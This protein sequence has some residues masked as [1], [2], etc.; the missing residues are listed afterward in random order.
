[1]SNGSTPVATQAHHLD[2]TLEEEY[3]PDL[4]EVDIKPDKYARSVNSTS[5]NLHGT[6]VGRKFSSFLKLGVTKDLTKSIRVQLDTP[7]LATHFQKN[8]LNY[9][10]LLGRRSQNSS[11]LVNNLIHL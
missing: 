8:L 1:M 2:A 9:R 10:S 11:P 4:F 3:E 7:P 6:M 5:Q